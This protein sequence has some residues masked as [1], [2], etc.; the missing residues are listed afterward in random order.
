MKIDL[1]FFC[2]ECHQVAVIQWDTAYV[3]RDV[4]LVCKR[5]GHSSGELTA[6]YAYR[7]KHRPAWER[8]ESCIVRGG[9]S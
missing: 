9:E 6:E 1:S 4:E 2:R 3:F 7:A 5:C 8:E